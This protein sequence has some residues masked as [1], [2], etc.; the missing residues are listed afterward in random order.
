MEGGGLPS[1]GSR[2][3][4]CRALALLT[5][6]HSIVRRDDT[7]SGCYPSY[8][9]GGGAW[10]ALGGLGVS[11]VESAACRLSWRLG[12]AWAVQWYARESMAG[13]AWRRRTSAWRARALSR[14]ACR[15]ETSLGGSRRAACL[16]GSARHRRSTWRTCARSRWVARRV[17]RT[18]CARRRVVG[19]PLAGLTRRGLPALG[20]L[21]GRLGG[22]DRRS[23][24]SPSAVF[25][26]ER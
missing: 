22:S 26:H 19:V 18:W 20:V 23:P 25:T 4:K 14:R 6:L 11:G 9:I 7:R 15:Q 17:R 16:G 13:S 3:Q 12:S 24:L 8:V 2:E 10:R 1:I 21:G 5:Q